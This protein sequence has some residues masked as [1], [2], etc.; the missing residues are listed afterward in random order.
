VARIGAILACSAAIAAQP[1][2]AAPPAFQVGPTRLLSPSFGYTVAYRTVERRDRVETTIGVFVFD[3]GRW[4][5]VTPPNLHGNLIDDVAFLDPQHGWVTAYDC[6][7]VNVYL[8]RTS[9]GG[10]TWESLG[11]PGSHSCGGGPT[12][13]SVVDP[14]HGW[15][16]PV[17]P[18]GPQGVL[19]RTRD[20]GRTWARI[21]AFNDALPC[22]APISF[23]SRTAGWMGRCDGHVYATRDGGRHWHAVAIPVPRLPRVA[24]LD[25]PRFFGTAGVEAA[26]LGDAVVPTAT[27]LRERSV[28][29]SVSADGGRSWTLRSVRPLSPCTQTG[30]VFFPTSWPGAVASARA[31]WVVATGRR[32]LVQI[33]DDGGRHWREFVPRGLPSRPCAVASVSAASVRVAWAVVRTAGDESG[34]YETRDAGRSWRRVTLV[35]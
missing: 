31:W 1:A 21:A 9:D 5:A 30:G 8:Y 6:G 18:N 3:R 27:S 26:T 23:T 14:T 20:G 35:R 32:P 11:T 10:R 29:F 33:T 16:E 19:L 25:V 13:L 7:D 22:L 2:A 24:R 15:L 4:R 17:S 12:W 28:A 34:L